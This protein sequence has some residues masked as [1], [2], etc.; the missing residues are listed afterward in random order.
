[1]QQKCQLSSSLKLRAAQQL[2]A[3]HLLQIEPLDRAV[4]W[5]IVYTFLPLISSCPQPALWRGSSIKTSHLTTLP[6]LLSALGE[7]KKKEKKE[8]AVKR[9]DVD[10]MLLGSY[11][12]AVL[13]LQGQS[14]GRVLER[15]HDAFSLMAQSWSQHTKAARSLSPHAHNSPV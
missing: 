10:R 2:E 8:R 1:M 11:T 15:P 9:Q 14:K 5:V 7:G 13:S 12:D 4:L 3:T 6:L